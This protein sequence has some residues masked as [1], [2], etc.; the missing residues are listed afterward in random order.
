MRFFRDSAH[1]NYMNVH[2]RDFPHRFVT[3]RGLD[4][5]PQF[6][7]I[8]I[9]RM[10]GHDDQAHYRFINEALENVEWN[11]I[12]QGN[13]ED[14][15]MGEMMVYRPGN[16]PNEQSIQ[17]R[18]QIRNI[19]LASRDDI[20]PVVMF[21]NPRVLP[22]AN[23][24]VIPRNVREVPLYG[25]NDPNYVVNFLMDRENFL[26][27]SFGL[28]NRVIDR[29]DDYRNHPFHRTR[30][31]NWYE[32]NSEMDSYRDDYFDDSDIDSYRSP[33]YAS[34]AAGGAGAGT[35]RR[36]RRRSIPR[37]PP[38]REIP[39]FHQPAAASTSAAAVAAST[40]PV[41]LQA[42][43]IQALINHAVSENM[44]CPISM[45]TIQK[46]TA[47]VT[48]CQHIFERDSIAR[49][50]TDHTNCPVCRQAT[51]ICN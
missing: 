5:T 27:E 47:C 29:L 21:D 18:F 39:D 17:T 16:N 10:R 4:P 40:R 37:T 36:T 44:T 13:R 7:M 20:Y 43:T 42:F 26:I 30:E 12:Y 1:G 45:N 15:Y 11:I 6:Q 28:S 31:R 41:T 2:P 22:H 3:C 51:S 35:D 32:R 19:Y 46:S 33:R 34:I 9:E 49:W 14:A 50:L 38:I 24:V 48:S 25:R 8:R 23:V